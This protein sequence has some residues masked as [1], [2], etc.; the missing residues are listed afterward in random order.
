ME[1]DVHYVQYNKSFHI[2][3]RI[4]ASSSKTTISNIKVALREKLKQ[5]S[6]MEFS[7][8]SHSDIPIFD[9]LKD[10]PIPSG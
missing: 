4:D 3:G 7:E 1:A 2:K 6:Y 8:V 9:A 10:I 5:V